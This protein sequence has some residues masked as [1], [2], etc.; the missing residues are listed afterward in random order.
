MPFAQAPRV[1]MTFLVR[2]EPGLAGIGAAMTRALWD[3]DPRQ[4]ITLQYTL[5]ERLDD[6]LQP[7]RFFARVVAGFAFAALVLAVLGVYAVATLQQRR[8]VGEFGLRLAIGATPSRLAR[9]ILGDSLNASIMGVGAGCAIAAT[10][11]RWF[12]PTRI[13]GE[14]ALP[15]IFACGAAVMVAAALLAAALPAWRVLR[16]MPMEALRDE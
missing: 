16:V 5:G 4:T 11:L 2:S 12:D 6:E 10:A 1:A 8:R 7:A 14:L 3:V 15:T 9:A 13:T